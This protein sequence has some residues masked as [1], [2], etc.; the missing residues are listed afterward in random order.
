[1]S[2]RPI[3]P[4]PPSSPPP[5]SATPARGRGCAR[6]AM[7][8]GAVVLVLLVLGAAATWYFVGRPLQQVY[9]AV[10][11]AERIESLDAR[12]ADRSSFVPPADGVLSEAQVERYVAVLERTATGLT[13]RLEDLQVRFEELDRREFVWTDVWRLADAYTEF[14]TLLTETKGAQVAA[15]NAEGFSQGEYAWV[16]REVLR[17]AGL[18]GEAA[19]VGA[20]VGSLVGGSDVPTATPNAVVPAVNVERVE[21]WRARLDEIGFLAVL[22]L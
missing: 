20:V 22:G 18:P 7:G 3:E 8:C 12:I 11:D 17:A 9:A 21:R 1:M 15:L 14:L 16:R 2:D 6:G 5:P 10:R 4:T 13:A 19:D